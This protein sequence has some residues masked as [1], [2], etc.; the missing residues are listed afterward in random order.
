MSEVQGKVSGRSASAGA[1]A[2]SGEAAPNAL[3]PREVRRQ[4]RIEMSRKQIL[5]IAEEMFGERGYQA[6]G[7]K[8]V[9]ERCEFSV[10]SIYTFFDGKDALYQEVLAR[11][12]AGQIEEMQRLAADDA[13]PARERLVQMARF[14]IEYFRRFPHWGRLQTRTLT[15]GAQTT[16]EVQRGFSKAYQGAMEIES[17]IFAAGQAE[18][19]IRSGD[20]VA[21]ARMF[22]ALVTSFHLMDPLVSDNPAPLGIEEFLAFVEH[23]FSP[24]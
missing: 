19:T 16:D 18:G 6:T 12:S 1:E 5:D 17:R 22:S 4:R 10:G 20:P 7:L 11:R 9:A 8:E 21:L 3:S 24:S 15:P 23:S 14:Q 2:V 13:T